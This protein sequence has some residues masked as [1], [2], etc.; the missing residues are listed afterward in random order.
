M[1]H[2]HLQTCSVTSAPYTDFRC[3][4]T[5]ENASCAAGSAYC[6]LLL[7][8]KAAAFPVAIMLSCFSCSATSV[9][10]WHQRH[11]QE[12][13]WRKRNDIKLGTHVLWDARALNRNDIASSSCATI[14]IPSRHCIE[15][16]HCILHII[17][18]LHQ[19]H[20]VNIAD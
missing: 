11:L 6:H 16:V 7:A 13:H 10:P 20:V 3:S 8:N 12:R 17:M 14:R 19:I 1:K 15:L 9:K 18:T 5:V 4:A 2:N